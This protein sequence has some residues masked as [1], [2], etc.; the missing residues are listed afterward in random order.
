MVAVRVGFGLGRVV[1]GIG[2]GK[3]WVRGGARVGGTLG[4]G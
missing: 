1:F 4:F 2:V 3:G